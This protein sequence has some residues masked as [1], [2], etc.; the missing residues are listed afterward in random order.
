MLELP[1][2]FRTYH[3]TLDDFEGNRTA[4]LIGDIDER[5]AFHITAGDHELS[6]IADD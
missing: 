4:G 1:Q 3:A 2:Q 6:L 5:A